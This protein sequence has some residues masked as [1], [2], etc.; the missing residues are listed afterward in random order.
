MANVP[1]GIVAGLVGT[2]ALSVLMVMKN[3]MGLMP[4]L[5]VIAMLA[6]MMHVPA[7]AAWAIHFMIGAVWGVMFALLYKLIPGGSPV[8]KGMIFG[9]GA[10]L[11]MMVV[12]MPMAGA[13]LFGMTLG[14]MAPLMTWMLHLVFGAVLGAT[15]GRP[16]VAATS[17]D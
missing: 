16:Y 6:G 17:P 8:G 2:V 13:G 14:M 1:K 5:D 9:T 15:F 7:A 11:M 12:V 4:E 3:A 10:W